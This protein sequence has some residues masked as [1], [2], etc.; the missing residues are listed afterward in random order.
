MHVV[1]PATRQDITKAYHSLAL[2]YHPDKNTSE[3][4]EER[5]KSILEAYMVLKDEKKR[6]VYDS[7]TKNDLPIYS[8]WRKSKTTNLQTNKGRQHEE[9]E[10]EYSRFTKF[11]NTLFS[12]LGTKAYWYIKI[13]RLFNVEIETSWSNDNEFDSEPKNVNGRSRNHTPRIPTLA[14]D[15]KL[16]LEEL[17]TGVIKKI[18]VTRLRLDNSTDI[19]IL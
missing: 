14:Y 17:N 6:Q 12:G 4:S 8:S 2:K 15:L 13:L 3:G 16:T 10:Y 5:F 18:K 7:V 1:W 19:N 11:V 9:K